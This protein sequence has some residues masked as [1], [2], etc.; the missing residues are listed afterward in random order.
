MKVTLS[1]A[2]D[3]ARALLESWGWEI[4]ETAPDAVL[5]EI[6]GRWEI[7]V[8]PAT[9]PDDVIFL[10]AAETELAWRIDAAK[11][12][13]NRLA[14]RLHDLRSPLNAVQGYAEM[15]VEVA[16]AD[17]LRFASNICTASENLV[18]RLQAFSEEGV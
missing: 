13:R 5:T 18:Q 7:R 17:C 1:P 12:R 16:E 3:Q 9:H 4:T 15:L 11:D 6:D 2:S 8:R 10:P 14:R